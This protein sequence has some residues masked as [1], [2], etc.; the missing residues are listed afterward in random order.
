[1]NKKRM[2]DGGDKPFYTVHEAAIWLGLSYP[3][4]SRLVRSGKLP[5]F[6]PG[7]I[8]WMIKEDDLVA[9]ESKNKGS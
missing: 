1:M 9:Y 8:E 4:V 6:K 5:A 7:N 2:A 3:Q